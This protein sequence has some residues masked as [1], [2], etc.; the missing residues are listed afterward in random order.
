[1]AVIVVKIVMTMVGN[2]V[3]EQGIDAVA[4]VVGK[5]IVVS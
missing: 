2:V 3:K 1:V 4:A 5:R